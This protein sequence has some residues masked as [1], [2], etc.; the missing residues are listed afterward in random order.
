MRQ[1]PANLYEDSETWAREAKEKLDLFAKNED[2]PNFINF[3]MLECNQGQ[4][5]LID[6]EQL[7]NGL[8][9]HIDVSF[10]KVYDRVQQMS[11]KFDLQLINKLKK[12]VDCQ[13]VEGVDEGELKQTQEQM[14]M[15]INKR[16]NTSGI[17]NTS[18]LNNSSGGLRSQSPGA[19]AN[20][21]PRRGNVYTSP[22]RSTM[23]PPQVP[24]PIQ[25]AQKKVEPAGFSR[26][27]I[28]RLQGN[29]ENDLL[30]DSPFFQG[31]DD[32]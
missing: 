16:A 11:F 26:N 24:T 10:Q 6:G 28:A 9:Q 27:S 25:V 18:G 22:Q 4:R 7:V 30:N 23:P 31:D 17:M 3:D 21:N 2:D 15:Q 32:F 19:S 8:E 5:L 1:V 20:Q 12:V 29:D 14:T 13:V